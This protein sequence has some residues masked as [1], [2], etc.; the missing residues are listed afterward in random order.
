MVRVNILALFLILVGESIQ[1][2][3]IKYHVSGRVL[4]FL[5]IFGSVLKFYLLYFFIGVQFVMVPFF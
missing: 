4:K 1:L 2:L 5:F 3:N